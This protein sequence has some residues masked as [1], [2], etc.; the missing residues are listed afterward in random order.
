VVYLGRPP[1]ENS[2][3]DDVPADKWMTRF[4]ANTEG[5]MLTVQH[6]VKDMRARY[7]G[8]IV[9]LSSVTAHHGMVGS[10]IPRPPCTASHEV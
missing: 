3:F 4:R 2:L 5:H 10:E 9:L 7:W 6:A 8:R 1:G